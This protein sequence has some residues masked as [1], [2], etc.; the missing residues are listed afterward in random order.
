MKRHIRSI[1]NF[2]SVSESVNRGCSKPLCVYVCLSYR[3]LC[4]VCPLTRSLCRNLGLARRRLFPLSR[5]PFLDVQTLCPARHGL[6]PFFRIPDLVHTHSSFLATSLY[7]YKGFGLRHVVSYD[8]FYSTQSVFCLPALRE[9]S[10]EHCAQNRSMPETITR[11]QICCEP[12]SGKHRSGLKISVSAISEQPLQYNGISSSQHQLFGF[13]CFFVCF[14]Q[15]A[16]RCFCSISPRQN[17]R[18]RFGPGRSF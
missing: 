7:V 9:R 6:C 13:L 15:A 4:H 5:S 11:S 3:R 1:G 10:L 8:K 16:S 17:L 14:F 18:R 12:Q 2:S